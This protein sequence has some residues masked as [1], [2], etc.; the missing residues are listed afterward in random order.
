MGI[1]SKQAEKVLKEIAEKCSTLDIYEKRDANDKY[2][3]L[4]INNKGINEC[5]KILTDA[6]GPAAKPPKIK[7][8]KEDALLTKGHG[9]IQ[10]NQTLFK[11][12]IAGLTVITML[13]PWQDNAHTTLKI[14]LLSHG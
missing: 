8:T 1:D 3:E 13:W 14:V 9:G 11:K 4:V 6:L 2:C 12:E 7:A 5:E 10:P